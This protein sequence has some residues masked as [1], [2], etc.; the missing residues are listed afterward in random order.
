MGPAI[1]RRRIGSGCRTAP[2]PFPAMVGAARCLAGFRGPPSRDPL[3]LRTAAPQRR[4]SSPSPASRRCSSSS[5]SCCVS[6]EKPAARARSTRRTRWRPGVG[7]PYFSARRSPPDGRSEGARRACPPFWPPKRSG[8]TSGA[9]SSGRRPGRGATAGSG[10][11]WGSSARRSPA[12]LRR[13][14]PAA[15]SN[16][17]RATCSSAAAASPEQAAPGCPAPELRRRSCCPEALPARPRCAF[18][19]QSSP[20]SPVPAARRGNLT[21]TS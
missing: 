1:S 14:A 21:R 5:S 9:R 16:S 6:Q 12:S 13:S 11:N 7:G 18:P 3:E 10:P 19:R 17:R 15:S 20:G 8:R 4:A 2:R